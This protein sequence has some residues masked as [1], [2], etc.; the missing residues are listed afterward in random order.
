MI[1]GAS[2]RGPLRAA[3]SPA[4]AAAAPPVPLGR[5]CTAMLDAG[6][7]HLGQR[8]GRRV[9]DDDALHAGGLARRA[10]ATAPSAGRRSR[11]APSGLRAHAGALARREDQNYGRAHPGDA[12]SLTGGGAAERVG[13]QGLE[14]RF[15][16][17]KPDVLPLDDPPGDGGRIDPRRYG[18]AACGAART[19]NL[20]NLRIAAQSS[21]HVDYAPRA[22]NCKHACTLWGE[23]D[24]GAQ[25]R[26]RRRREY[27]RRAHRRLHR[28]ARH[29]RLP[30]GARTPIQAP[31]SRVPER[32]RARSCA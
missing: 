29:R 14:P 31:S 17:P 10:R 4:I 7:Q 24:F 23:G 5:G 1:T 2:A 15:S 21:S 26:L 3:E 12:Y 30:R 25:R 6:G 32:S 19:P 28:P 8:A 13:G 11:A 18:G 27:S 22:H 9:D 20:R 16:G